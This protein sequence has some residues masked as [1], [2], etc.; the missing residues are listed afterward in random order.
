MFSP[1]HLFVFFVLFKFLIVSSSLMSPSTL[2]SKELVWDV[3]CSAST[4]INYP[5]LRPE[6][7]EVMTQVSAGRRKR[8]WDDSEFLFTQ[9][10]PNSKGPETKGMDLGSSRHSYLVVESTHSVSITGHVCLCLTPLESRA[11]LLL[12]FVT[13]W[14]RQCW[15]RGSVQ[16]VFWMNM[17]FQTSPIHIHWT[18][19]LG[20][21]FRRR[22]F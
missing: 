16:S 17:P 12:I 6:I 11:C 20:G 8:H 9:I 7:E 15:Y 4:E 5:E 10:S 2:S 18:Y 1:L 19:N 3:L 21:I 22:Y 13:Q 14:P